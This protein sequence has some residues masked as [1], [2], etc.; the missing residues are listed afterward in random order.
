MNYA[1]YSSFV[2]MAGFPVAQLQPTLLERIVTK[3]F[4]F[5]YFKK[6]FSPSV[7]GK[8]TSA[9]NKRVRVWKNSPERTGISTSPCQKLG[10]FIGKRRKRTKMYIN[11]GMKRKK[12]W[13]LTSSIGSVEVNRQILQIS[14]S[15]ASTEYGWQSLDSVQVRL[16][17]PPCIDCHFSE[18][19]EEFEQLC[20]ILKK[21]NI[22]C[23]FLAFHLPTYKTSYLAKEQCE[24]LLKILKPTSVAMEGTESNRFEALIPLKQL[25]NAHFSLL[26]LLILLGKSLPNNGLGQ[27]PR[28]R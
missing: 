14:E 20:D 26:F 5:P 12:K 28:C 16:F 15:R 17:L 27:Y 25:V 6:K 23:S 9:S 2:Q 10:F 3:V 8:V 21:N 19:T 4:P 24:E 1:D 13:D 22:T 7:S 18:I 11:V